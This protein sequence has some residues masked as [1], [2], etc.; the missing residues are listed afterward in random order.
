MKFKYLQ[1]SKLLKKYKFSNFE[2]ITNYGLF[3]GDVNLFKTLKI[4]ELLMQVKNVKG[5]IIELGIDK[6]NTSLLIK[7]IL[8]IY[9]I[10]KKLFLLDHFKGLIHYTKNDTVSSLKFQNRFSAPK[11]VV[12]EFLN[13]FKLKNVEILTQDA[14]KIKKGYFKDKKFC[15]AYFDMDLY[16]PTLQALKS[17]DQ[18]MTKGGLIVFDQGN[19]K[20]WGERFA[21]KEFLKSNKS[22]KYFLISKTRQPDVVLLKKT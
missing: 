16:E 20:I 15:L 8:D 14:T 10:K 22:Y 19:Q 1:I 13:F 12:L 6:G 2:L 4:F 5:D 7:K 9:K 11:K 3:S 18:N 21:I 17:I